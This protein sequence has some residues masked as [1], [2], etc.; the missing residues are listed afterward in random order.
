VTD[1][2]DGRDVRVV[3]QRLVETD[4]VR[5]ALLVAPDG[6]VIASALRDTIAVEAISALAATLGREL[7]TGGRRT[8]PDEAVGVAQFNS[9]GGTLYLGSTAI[10]FVAILATDGADRSRLGADVREA[11]TTIER[12]WRPALSR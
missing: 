10:G 9:D 1:A 11:V 12:A 6:L 8:D 4:G 3:L 2:T 5:G 7:E